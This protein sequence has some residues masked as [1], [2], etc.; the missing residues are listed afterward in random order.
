MKFQQPR[1]RPLTQRLRTL[2]WVAIATLIF[3]LALPHPAVEAKVTP[4]HYT[5][6]VLPPL[7]K[8]KL[9][10]YS[11]FQLPNGIT[12]Y[13]VEDHELPLVSGLALFPNGSRQEPP[14]QTGLGAITGAVMRSGGTTSQSA[15]ALN[16]FLENK[17]ASVESY[18]GTTTSGVNF[19][20]L[21]DDLPE[22]FAIFTDVLRHPA[23]EAAK[24]ELAKSR[25]QG[26]IPR[27]NDDPGRILDREFE[28][29]VYGPDSPYA[30]T[31]EY[32]T[33]AAF[34]REDA[35]A[36]YQQAFQPQQMILGIIGDFDSAALKPLLKSKLADWQATRPPLPANLAPV[37]Q[38]QQGLFFAEQPQLN[39]S[40][41]QLGHLG[42][43]L[44]S[45]DYPALS[46]MNQVLNGFGG[47]LFNQVRS[48]QGLAYS[49][50]AAWS[51]QYDFPG[52]FV[53]G[54]QTR[55]ETTVQFIQ[56]LRQELNQ[57]R[58]SSI[59]EAELQRA[60]DKV[61]NSFVFNFQDPS[62]TLS[63][64]LWY[65]LFRYPQDFIFK[66]QTAV[67]NTTAAD[68][69]RVAKTYL[70]PDQMVT[71][72]V[73]STEQIRPPLQALE[74]GD[75]QVRTLDITIPALKS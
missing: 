16:Q 61:L 52:V 56:A 31:V 3:C 50:Y 2:T 18:V 69:L 9:P 68:V 20:S 26:G 30:R 25:V 4:K 14:T 7:A 47:R 43:I 44:S 58:T 10:K 27:R 67:E 75:K 46:V 40:Y 48:R 6:L 32:Q 5:D 8:V 70:Q 41:V 12:V 17:A 29:L 63:R 64:L 23:F 45:P 34:S 53:A 74:T 66:Y 72:V 71:L 73:G 39:Q 15:D 37:N 54:G 49:V 57:L 36:F 11:T 21:A 59:S 33:L 19:S 62:Q 65:Q 13:L 22:V 42:G 51:P 24:F 35:I 1:I 55:A 60:K 28:K 38:H